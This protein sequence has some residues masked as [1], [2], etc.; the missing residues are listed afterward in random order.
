[1]CVEAD[2]AVCGTLFAMTE[3]MR[4][5]IP[6]WEGRVSPVFDEASRIL[7]VD[8]C[9]KREQHRHEESLT[10]RNPFERA[11]MLPKLG[12]DIL[13]C[14]V[15]SQTQHTAISSA[16]IRVIPH[17]CGPT[18]EVIAAFLEGRI[19]NGELRMPGCRHSKR[20]CKRRV[21]MSDGVTY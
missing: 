2:L 13:V 17:I 8:V 5:A 18:D 19:E 20:M 7:L 15:I 11:Q 6:L 21:R 4:I 3:P 14:G 9:D 12:V 1:M 10:V 16:G